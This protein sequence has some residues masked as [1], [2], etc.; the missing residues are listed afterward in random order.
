MPTD[1]REAIGACSNTSPWTGPLPASK[2]GGTGAGPIDAS[3]ST[4]YPWP[5]A[6]LSG[7][8]DPATLPTYTATQTVI[9]LSPATY[10]TSGTATADAGSG[11][12]NTAD[13]G[14]MYTPIAGCAYPSNAWD[15]V[16]ATETACSGAAQ[17]VLR[18]RVVM[19]RQT[20]V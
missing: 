13:Q 19:P 10:T 6:S 11:W 14:G 16:D 5:P 20:G 12:A 17:R 3:Y 15:A 8:L 18:G 1:P 2:T 9:T 7:G 4:A